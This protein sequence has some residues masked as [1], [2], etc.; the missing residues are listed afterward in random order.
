MRACDCRKPKPVMVATLLSQLHGDH[1]RSWMIGDGA[2]DIEA[3]RQAGLKTALVF[4]PT[5]CELCPL[6]GGPMV[7]APD[8]HGVTL[9]EVARAIMNHA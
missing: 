6:R 7:L 2:G 4:A 3:G 9:L 1:L 5:R 8:V